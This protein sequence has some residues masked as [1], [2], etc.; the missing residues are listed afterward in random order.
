MNSPVSISFVEVIRTGYG[1]ETI[2]FIV[3]TSDVTRVPLYCV[4]FYFMGLETMTVFPKFA[5]F[6]LAVQPTFNVM[7]P[8]RINVHRTH[9]R[10]IDRYD[11]TRML[12]GIE[13]LIS[14]L[15][16]DVERAKHMEM[17]Q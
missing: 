9:T 6:K 11:R 15:E 3:R 7:D 1:Y 4:C 14:F 12:N 17:E 16:K 5:L 2:L 8:T 10:C 13:T